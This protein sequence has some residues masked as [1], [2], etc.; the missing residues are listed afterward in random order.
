MLINEALY[1]YDENE[2]IITLHQMAHEEDI[3]HIKNHLYCAQ[4]GCDCKIEY[5]P[6]GQKNAYFKKWRGDDYE[7]DENC[8]YHTNNVNGRRPIRRDGTVNSTLDH[9]RK[10]RIAR[11]VYQKYT[12]TAEQRESRLQRQRERRRNVNVTPINRTNNNLDPQRILDSRV[13]TNPDA[14]NVMEVERAPRLLRRYSINDI[15]ESNL[16][17]TLVVVGPLIKVENDFQT[18]SAKRSVLTISDANHNNEF[19]IFLDPVFFVN[20]FAN[21][22]SV[23]EN[24][25]TAVEN[26]ENA[27]EFILTAIGEI[28][29]RENSLSMAVYNDE[30]L[31]LNGRGIFS[32][33]TRNL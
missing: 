31:S 26:S 9:Q 28:L 4:D 22:D 11:D 15:G 18:S 13:T 23:L 32:S 17:E 6:Q 33:V 21:I 29:I 10:R 2:R 24:L 1:K 5:V 27:E 16:H 8:I 19:K 30:D 12:E 14:E 7:H 20:S 3:Q 25:H